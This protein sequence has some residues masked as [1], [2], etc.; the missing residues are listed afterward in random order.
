MRFQEI[1]VTAAA[2]SALRAGSVAASGSPIWPEPKDI[3][4]GTTVLSVDSS[5][6]FTQSASS[7]LLNRA[8]ERYKTLLAVPAGQSG[9]LNSC[10]ITVTDGSKDKTISAENLD[11]HSDE[12]Y[13]LE[14]GVDGKCSIHAATVWGA[15]HGME[16][17]T[18]LLQRQQQQ[19]SSSVTMSTSSDAVVLNYAPVSISDAPR[20]THRGVMIDSSRHFLPME[21]IRKVIDT[22][23]ASK[24]N[25]LH[26]H[27]V[28]A[29][30]FPLSLP[31]VPDLAQG[32]YTSTM[33]YSAQDLADIRDYA[34]DRGVRIVYEVDVPGHA[35]SW[36]AGYPQLMADCLVKYSYNINDFALNPT[37]DETYSVLNG[38]LSDISTS[39]GTKYMH[40]G[41]DEVV[42]GCWA[43]DTSITNWMAEQEPAMTSY[44][45]LLG[46]FVDKADGQ[47]YDLGATPV[48]WEEVFT[49]GIRPDPR[50]IFQVWT[51]QS[52]IQAIVAAKY[53]VIAS[54]SDV[55]YLDIAS[56]TWDVMYNYDPSVGLSTTE[57]EYIL[58]GETALWGERVDES[59][60]IQQ[61]YPRASAVA[62]RLW[63]PETVTDI[64]YAKERLL[65]QRCRLIQRGFQSA[66]VEPGYCAEVFV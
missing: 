63:S 21:T 7:E 8:M 58:G 26:W 42:Y 19:K 27:T 31:S 65:I 35:A 18:Q 16:S 9:D 5:F 61:M 38:V 2:A 56:N 48:H 41:G 28:D 57:K 23:P 15:L 25:V 6:Q 36:A 13:S 33:T 10:L 11:L 43:N 44:N 22:L 29:Q 32:A 17:F 59:N 51:E 3:S 14:I 46:Y 47:I 20:Y 12:S 39:T 66:P 54:P 50:T 34:F 24:F 30:S 37:L 62:E 55:W 64:D 60:I 1:F 52:K 49:A 45:Q 40:I 4:L 53:N